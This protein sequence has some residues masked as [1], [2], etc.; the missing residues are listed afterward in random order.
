MEDYVIQTGGFRG[1]FETSVE[2]R[3]AVELVSERDGALIVVAGEGA[4][5]YAVDCSADGVLGLFHY[6][7]LNRQPNSL[8]PER[9]GFYEF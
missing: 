2:E 9:F 8:F 3:T 4:M 5:R 1:D 7:N 6:N